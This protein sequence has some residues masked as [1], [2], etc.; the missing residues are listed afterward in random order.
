[1][2]TAAWIAGVALLCLGA[3]ADRPQL[4]PTRDVDVTYALDTGGGPTL[5][6]RL[7]WDVAAEKLRID[8]P[9]AGLYVIIDLKARRMSTVRAADQTVIETAA[10]PSATGMPDSAAAGATRQGE[11]VVAGL[12]CT[13]WSVTDAAGEPM[14]VCLTADGVLLRARTATRT[15]LTATSVQYGPVDP[16]AYQVPAE[17]VHRTLGAR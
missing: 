13:D 14:T 8:P 9:T 16:V 7:R 3:G 17:Y 4:R 5:R 15:L 6:E 2:K 12:A 10:P 1:V 11:G